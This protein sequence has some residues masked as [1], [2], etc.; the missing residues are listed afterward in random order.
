MNDDGHPHEPE[1]FAS[2]LAELRQRTAAVEAVAEAMTIMPGTIAATDLERA[3]ADLAEVTQAIDQLQTDAPA[4][5]LKPLDGRLRG[6][7]IT[8]ESA[9]YMGGLNAG[10]GPSVYEL[11]QALDAALTGGPVASR[12]SASAWSWRPPGRNP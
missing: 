7:A 1:E 4:K 12:T 5:L 3:R 2:G 11:K 10:S 6:I 9:L 8:I